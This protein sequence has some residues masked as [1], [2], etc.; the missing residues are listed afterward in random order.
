MRGVFVPSVER[1]DHP[2]IDTSDLLDDKGTEQHQ[3]LIGKLQW[4]MSLGRFGIA[5][6]IMT[7]SGFRSA[8]REGHLLQTKLGEF[9]DVFL[10]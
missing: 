7:M 6:A 2:E 5:V 8:P 10:K 3:L 9:V 1:G 4:A